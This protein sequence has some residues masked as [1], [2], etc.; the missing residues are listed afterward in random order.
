MMLLRHSIYNLLVQLLS[1]SAA[2]CGLLRYYFML[3]TSIIVT[4]SL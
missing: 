2:C 1:L 4:R 3:R